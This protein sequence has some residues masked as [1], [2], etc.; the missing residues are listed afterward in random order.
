MSEIK[1]INCQNVFNAEASDAK[2]DA[3]CPNCGTLNPVVGH[4]RSAKEVIFCTSCGKENHYNNYKCESCDELLHGPVAPKYVAGDGGVTTFVPYK[5]ACGLAAYYLGVFA[6]IP[7]FGIPLGVA[8]LVTGILGVRN[9]KKNPKIK[10]AVHA[11]IGII[12]GFITLLLHG[13]A[14]GL[15][16]ADI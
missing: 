13:I 11:W 2:Q 1:C 16:V 3:K 6:L 10:G 5:N 9:A 15:I 12:L 14:I 8:A 7:C 4:E